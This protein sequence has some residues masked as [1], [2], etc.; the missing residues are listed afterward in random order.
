VGDAEEAHELAQILAPGGPIGALYDAELASIGQL[1]AATEAANHAN[2]AQAE[3]ASLSLLRHLARHRAHEHAIHALGVLAVMSQRPEV[4]QVRAQAAARGL[5][6]LG[7]LD[8]LDGVDPALRIPLV[9]LLTRLQRGDE[10]PLVPGPFLAIA[11]DSSRHLRAVCAMLL[12]RFEDDAAR[13]QLL[14]MIGDPEPIVR[15]AAVRAM[16]AKSRLTRDLLAKVLDDKDARVRHAAVRAVSGTTSS[17]MPALDPS[18]FAQ[19]KAGVGKPGAYATLDANAAM[20]SLTVIEKMML[21]RQVP[22]FAELD[23]DDL[24]ELADIVE[25]RRIEPGRDVFREGDPGDAVYLIVK[26]VHR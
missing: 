10:G 9:E 7:S 12:S 11:A 8:A 6:R 24:E 19:T 18:M 22:I 2:A 5:V 25:E 13:A 16:G 17:E 21:I 3:S 15:E 4:E 23:P 26:G 14:V 1:V 20:A